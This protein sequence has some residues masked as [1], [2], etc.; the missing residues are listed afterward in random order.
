MLNLL[1][2][3]SIQPYS[4]SEDIND[5]QDSIDDDNIDETNESTIKGIDYGTNATSIRDQKL[6]DLFGTKLYK[7]S[8]NADNPSA[9]TKEIQEFPTIQ[10]LK[11]AKV[12]GIYFSASWCGPCRQ[13][14]PI[15]S[16]FYKYVNKHDKNNFEIIFASRDRAP[17]EFLDYY[18]KMPWLSLEWD[19]LQSI[20]QKLAGIYKLQG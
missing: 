7:W 11:N 1:L 13:F 14:T 3:T 15:L 12:I 17:R 8:N 18:T 10:L 4:N 19:R 9:S 2:I 6:I 5:N 16:E 20:V